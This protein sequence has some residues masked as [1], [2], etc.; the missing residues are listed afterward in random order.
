MKS[1]GYGVWEDLEGVEEQEKVMIKY[2]LS[3]FQKMKI[4]LYEVNSIKWN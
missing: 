1:G 4:S 3:K 2:I